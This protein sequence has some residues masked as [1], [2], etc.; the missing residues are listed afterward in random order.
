MFISRIF[1]ALCIS[2]TCFASTDPLI[3]RSGG[4]NWKIISKGSINTATTNTV[5]YTITSPGN[6]MLSESIAPTTGSSTAIIQINTNDVVLDL[7]S[8]TI[9]GA[10]VT[11]KGIFINGCKNI[12]IQ[13]GHLASIQ[14]MSIHI[15]AG[16]SN[17]RIQDVTITSP[18][19]STDIQLDGVS[20]KLSNIT[21]IGNNSLGNSIN[22]AN[23][24]NDIILE[25]IRI[26]NIAG[27][28]IN[29]GSSCYNIRLK[30]I[31]IDT[32]TGT[33]NG[34]AVGTTCYDIL[35]D[36]LRISNTSSDS[37]LI[38]NNCYGMIIKNGSITNSAGLGINIGSNTH[39]IHLSNLFITGCQNGILTA[40]INGGVIDNC[41]ISRSIGTNAYACKLVASQNIVIQ[42]S[43][44]FESIS[45]G[46]SVSGLWLVTCTNISCSNVQSSGHS[47]AQ[48]Y[49]FKADTNC[50]GCTFDTCIS[51]GNIA[52]SITPGQGA[53]GFYL[54]ASKGFTFNQCTSA[55]HQGTA[56]A[57]GFY[58]ATTNAN[59]YNNCK[60]LQNSATTGSATALA[61]GFYS[62]GGNSN[63]W[64]ECEANGQ[65][66][67]STAST[68][69]YGAIGFYLST[70]Y[71]SSLYRCKALGNGSFTNHAATAAGFYLDATVNPACKCL[72]IREC[73]A[74]S[75][76]TSATS[77]ISAY[78]FWDT[79]IGTS[80]VFI[81][82]YS[83][84]NS[85]SATP[86]IV[87]NYAA[88]LPIGGTNPS[89]FPRVEANLDGLLDI[90]NKPLFYNVSITS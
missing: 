88:N 39:G 34:I 14:N 20:I 40:G 25:T 29:I 85:D 69:G 36:G 52:T 60:A 51:R 73:A 33:N 7:A 35:C 50:L 8:H 89:N 82:C 62:V 61:L 66:A 37:L 67:G 65:N 4:E 19:N 77:G 1:I 38:G 11:G 81:D 68:A 28:G 13:T 26:S 32:C 49:G 63:K 75:N 76:C 9:N 55:N 31:E 21:I 43:N 44:F 71:Q 83:A 74:N 46:N 47:G 90:A 58:E 42:R 80:N 3:T 41:T 27:N 18:G 24:I 22:L 15:G 17:I 10:G 64:Q 23:S 30:G 53:F 86:R 72:E 56:L 48:S 78:G 54:S 12:T 84:S 79:A 57:V 59:T 45:E 16:S 2:L 87:T 70:E 5:G 6:Y